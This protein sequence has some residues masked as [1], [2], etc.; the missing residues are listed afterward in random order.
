MDL[1]G[2]GAIVYVREDAINTAI[3]TIHDG[4]G[5]WFRTDVAFSA[6][7][8]SGGSLS[9]TGILYLT[10]PQVEFV[11][12]TDE[13]VGV[14]VTA[15]ARVRIL[16]NGRD[17][18]DVVLELDAD[19]A[20][21]VDLSL[22]VPSIFD[23]IQLDFS[24]F[25]IDAASIEVLEAPVELDPDTRTV[26]L[27]DTVRDFLVDQ[28]RPLA[29]DFLR[30]SLPL[31]SLTNLYDAAFLATLTPIPYL[32]PHAVRPFNGV[33]AIGFDQREIAGKFIT[34]GRAADIALPWDEYDAGIDAIMALEHDQFL[35]HSDKLD[36]L[37]AVDAGLLNT[38]MNITLVDKVLLAGAGSTLHVNRNGTSATLENSGV[39]LVLDGSVDAPDP[40][41][42]QVHF[43]VTL[44]GRVLAEPAGWGVFARNVNVDADYPGGL[45]VLGPTF[46]PA[47]GDAIVESIAEGRVLGAI[48]GGIGTIPALDLDFVK[49]L[50][51]LPAP[52]T[53]FSTVTGVVE[54]QGVVLNP[55]CAMVGATGSLHMTS[56]YG[57]PFIPQSGYQENI[58]V[59]INRY[60]MLDYPSTASAELKRDPSLKIGLTLITNEPDGIPPLV[61]SWWA[62]TG[63]APAPK[64][65]WNDPDFIPDTELTFTYTVTRGDAA[66]QVLPPFT[67]SISIFDRLDWHHPYYHDSRI[68]KWYK[69]QVVNG[70]TVTVL[71]GEERRRGAIHK[72]KLFDRCEFSGRATSGA[73][74]REYMDALPPPGIPDPPSAEFSNRLCQYCF[75]II[76]KKKGQS[77]RAPQIMKAKRFSNPKKKGRNAEQ[78]D[79]FL[80]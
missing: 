57:P 48:S 75:E 51:G 23:D 69:D 10:T 27:S 50:P 34:N 29:K 55:T 16:A 79:P 35:Q 21:P 20:A 3:S 13:S 1:A 14:K 66:A 56:I 42:G 63:Q 54:V 12:S 40:L 28:L 60:L 70:K 47:I 61:S 67:G 19:V 22:V 30:V 49:D 39:A 7:I 9:G 8:P 32:F 36:M 77:V 17:I 73:N 6:P 46:V 38:I 72:T 24:N 31:D 52:D 45:A 44:D 59:D 33:L 53:G 37:L 64:D 43:H 26:I 58:N 15:Y 74:Q 41:P 5:S 25:H 76:P 18:E 78:S 80:A 68:V 65:C 71:V 4:Y 11:D 62:D 2:F